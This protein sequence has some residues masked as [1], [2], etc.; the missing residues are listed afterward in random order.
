[1]E[2]HCRTQAQPLQGRALARVNGWRT[3][4]RLSARKAAIAFR[5]EGRENQLPQAIFIDSMS[6]F[7]SS[8]PR[9]GTRCPGANASSV[10]LKSFSE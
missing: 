9:L 3:L 6:F 10:P 5:D 1:M 4:I 2:A 8:F 7:M